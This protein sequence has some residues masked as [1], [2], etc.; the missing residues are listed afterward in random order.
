MFLPGAGGSM[1]ADDGGSPVKQCYLIIDIARCEDC[2]NCSLAC[3]DE[4]VDNEWPGYS[5]AQPR[6]GHRWINVARHERGQFPL[7]DVA[8][9]PMPCMQCEDAP[10]AGKS[11]GAIARRSDGVVLIDPVK[12]RGRRELVDS[13]PYGA[14]FWN[15]E[16]QLPQKCTLCAH[17][18]D[19]GWEAPRC[20]QACPTGALQF[21][22]L[23]ENEMAA[24]AL[25]GKLRCLHPEL[26]TRPHVYY[27]NLNRFDRCFIAGSVASRR[28]GR[29]EC[30]GGARVVLLRAG[31][32]YAEMVTDPFGDFKFD[33]LEP[34]SVGYEIQV[35]AGDQLRVT[36]VVPQL[37]KSMSFGTLWIAAVETVL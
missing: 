18:L 23:E 14:I 33:G 26:G 28:I 19:Q 20:V 15:E 1:A 35:Y 5:A 2:N 36:E 11:E 25:D 10:C 30:V 13:C 21:K 24:L 4:H 32:K 34:K 3:K 22:R 7:I 16:N 17:L 6:H 8:Y 29:D 12:A 37:E 9:R 31:A 27:A